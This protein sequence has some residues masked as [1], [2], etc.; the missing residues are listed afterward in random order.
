VKVNET[1]TDLV[2]RWYNMTVRQTKLSLDTTAYISADY[3]SGILEERG[4]K[5]TVAE[6][7]ALSVG[8]AEV[9]TLCASADE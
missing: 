7:A 9:V 3:R 4:E 1:G 8:P 2:F 6:Y 5:T